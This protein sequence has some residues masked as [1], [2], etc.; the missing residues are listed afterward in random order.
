MLAAI[1]LLVSAAHAVPPRYVERPKLA[2][3]LERITYRAHDGRSRPAWLL[4]PAS[5]HGQ[6]IALV[7]SPH[8][9]GISARSDA[10]DWGDLPAE[11]GFAVICP[12]GEGRRLRLYSWG[13]PGEIADLAKMPAVAA[14]H[15]VRVDRRRVYAVGGSMGGQETLLLVARDPDVLAGAVAFD[16]VTDMTRRYRDFARLRDGRELRRIARLEIGGTPLD[17][18]A[19]YAARSPDT[20]ARALAHSGVP[21]QIYW[22]ADDGVIADQRAQIRAFAAAIERLNPTAAVNVYRGKW[23]HCAEMKPRRELPR[24]LAR[25]GLLPEVFGRLPRR[26]LEPLRRT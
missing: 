2:T 11:G 18:A 20:Y 3:R 15:G 17:D 25:L 12:A 1:A 19:A 13:D 6:P 4:L 8:G 23:H 24:A 21:M 9:R 16:P 7:V 10:A 26:R 5:Y 14:A 22:S